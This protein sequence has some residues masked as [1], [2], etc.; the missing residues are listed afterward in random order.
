MI[1]LAKNMVVEPLP[2]ESGSFVF[3]QAPLRILVLNRQLT[4]VL[5]LLSETDEESL[6]AASAVLTAPDSAAPNPFAECV[7]RLVGLGVLLRLR[8]A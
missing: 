8:D 6:L 4:Q 3:L 7:N 1:S 5:K 2:D